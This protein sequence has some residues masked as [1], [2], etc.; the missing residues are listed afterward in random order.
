MLVRREVVERVGM[1]DE[2]FRLY[3]EDLDWAFR[4]KADGWRVRYHPAVVVL[5]LK[6]QSSR[7]R[8]VSS[9]RSFYDAMRIFY[10]K[11]YARQH[12][13][14]FN[15]IVRL[16]IKGYEAAALVRNRLRPPA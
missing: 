12:S 4:I 2:A 3:G 6:G 5:H 11:H 15:A 16:S 10:D 8:P 1:F 9:I 13:A 14:P 7:Q